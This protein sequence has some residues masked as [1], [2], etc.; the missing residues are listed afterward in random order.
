[1]R[2]ITSQDGLPLYLRDY[3]GPANSAR[4]PILC[5]GGLTRNS[6]DF[7]G[8]A[9]FHSRYRRVLCPDT[10]GRGFSAYD[11]VWQ[12]YHPAT[13]IEDVRHILCALGVHGVVVIGTSM[14][15]IMG[16]GMA[17]AMPGFLKGLVLNDVGPIVG[18]QDLA[19]ILDY[20]ADSPSLASWAE[21]GAHLRKAFG[22]E[23]PLSGDDNWVRAAK[24]SY[25]ER[26]DGRIT[27]DWDTNLVKPLLADKADVYDIWHL[28]EA[29]AHIPV[30]T[31]RGGKSDILDEQQLAEMTRRHPSMRSVVVPGVGHPPSL[32]EPVSLEALNGFLDE[33]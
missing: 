31:V 19:R 27:F 26:P 11:P 7:A 25:V 17:A 23:Y 4:L 29:L 8:L 13:Y 24:N 6:K 14:G 33:F 20:I 1:M 22:D 16:M 5:L 32:A 28:F 9:K 12:N 10:R 15:G 30:L 2:R 3:P 21:A 18:R